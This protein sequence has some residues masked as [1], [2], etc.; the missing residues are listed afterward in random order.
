MISYSLSSNAAVGNLSTRQLLICHVFL[1]VLK[2]SVEHTALHSCQLPAVALALLWPQAVMG[3]YRISP[4]AE[5]SFCACWPSRATHVH[6]TGPHL[7]SDVQVT[8]R[9]FMG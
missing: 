8:V 1:P 9:V 2:L 5:C 7:V 6:T 4:S 3:S